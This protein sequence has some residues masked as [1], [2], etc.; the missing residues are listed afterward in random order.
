MKLY[1]LNEVNISDFEMTMQKPKAFTNLE[2]AQAEMK[3]RAKELYDAYGNGMVVEEG[4]LSYCQYEDG[5]ASKESNTLD[6]SIIEI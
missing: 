4:K 5:Y 3:K 2:D 1:I 6:I